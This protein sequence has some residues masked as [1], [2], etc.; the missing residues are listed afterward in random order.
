MLDG[1]TGFRHLLTE[2]IT[3]TAGRRILTYSDHVR[4]AV[5]A[6]AARHGLDPEHLEDPDVW[7]YV[8]R[9][10]SAWCGHPDH[11]YPLT[12][13]GDRSISAAFATLRV[14]RDIGSPQA[15]P[16]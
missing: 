7:G 15:I 16:S 3:L 1:A 5:L 6:D 13:R 4:E 2:L 12:D 10:R 14:L 11:Y 9:A 8:T